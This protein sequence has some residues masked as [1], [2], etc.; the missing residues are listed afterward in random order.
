MKEYIEREAVMQAF[1]DFAWNSNHSGLVPAPQWNHAVE[2]VRD[3]PAADVVE[4]RHGRW[5]LD[6]ET[7][8]PICSECHSGKP[9][10]CVCSS[11]ID[12][13]LGNHEIRYCYYCGAK[14]DGGADGGAN[15]VSE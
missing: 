10:K 8:V 5:I 1:A 7:G 2:I 6:D 12:H 9:T 15:S 11:V 13:T 14:M 4:V 3:F